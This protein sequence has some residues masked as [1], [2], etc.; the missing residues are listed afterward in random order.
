MSRQRALARADRAAAAAQRAEAARIERERAA[1]RRARQQRRSLTWRRLRLW[2]H[3]PSFQRRR[4]ALGALF[5][6]VLA[7][8]L[9]VYLFTGSAANVV[10][11]L[12]VFVVAGPVLVLLFFDRRRS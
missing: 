1:A 9:L 3:G 2:Q 6:L 4:E 11:T 5:T 10:V 12:L 8:S 7:T